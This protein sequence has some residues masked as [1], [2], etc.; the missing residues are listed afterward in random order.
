MEQKSMTALVSA[1]ARAYHSENNTVKIF[2]DSVARR[3]LTNE[4]YAQI[5]DSMSGGISFFNS[6]FIGDKN[7]ALR[8]VTDNQLSPSPLARA[9]FTEKSLATATQIGAKQYLIF[10]A[11][12]DTFAYRQPDFAKRLRIFEIDRA[13][14][15]GDKKSRL[16]NAGI[17]APENVHFIDAD[18]SESGWEN[19]LKKNNFF[20]KNLISFCSLL[21]LVYYISEHTFDAMLRTVSELLPKEA[22]LFS[23]IPTKTATPR[24][25][26]HAQKSRQCLQVPQMK[27]CLP[28]IRM[29]KLKSFSNHTAF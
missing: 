3:L 7:A 21:G 18:F 5:A 25:R 2:D 16:C 1:F 26:E 14:V 28:D 13:A 11:G 8:W 27:I 6:S 10:A 22:Q 15:V 12:Y 19:E 9:A 20:D 29:K 23:I 4:E 24:R 17:T